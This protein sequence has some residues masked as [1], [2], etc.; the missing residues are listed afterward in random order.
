MTKFLFTTLPSNDLGLLTRSLPIAAELTDRGHQVVFCSPGDA[1]S[2]LIADAG[3]D[4]FLPKHPLYYLLAASP[5]ARGLLKVLE[6]GQQDFRGLPNFLSQ[7][8]Q[9]APTR[10]ALPTSQVWDM[11]HLAAGAG[12]RSKNYVRSTCEAMM[13]LI[14]DCGA[15]VVVDFCNPFACVGARALRKPLVTV[16][17]ANMHPESQGFI[18]WRKRPPDLPTP[19]PDLNQ[20]LAEYKLEPIAK[21]GE[22]LLGDLTLVV[23]MPETD[24]LPATAAVTYVGAILWQKP[25]AELP[26]WVAGLSADKP[27]IWAYTGNPRYVPGLR[28]P[29][30]SAAVLHA[31]I[32]ALADED[33]Q[34]V[35]TTGHHP[36][37]RG[38]LPLPGNFR[39]AP[40][41]PGLA[42]ARS[43]DLLIHHGGYGSCQTGLYTGTPAVIIPTY[44]ERES[45][46]RRIVAAGAG[47]L[48]V[49]A[50]GRWGKKHV[51][52]DELRAKV[53]KVIS[54]PSYTT[55]AERMG[56][57]LRAY[58]GAPEAARLIED[59]VQRL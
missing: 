35:L 46:A 48:V 58:G 43:S 32:E 34:I 51:L 31:C 59:L 56:R 16:I 26:D 6:A 14:A 5:N 2:R 3:F 50:E 21:T 7:L 18:W 47:D 19:V 54:E 41:V 1:P 12:M 28:T 25:G 53:R 33:M 17:Q 11:D 36:L 24:P 42:M 49:P 38:I 40:F 30:D 15:N 44:S 8:I 52:V 37:P 13:T 10:I 20:V 9:G 55:N 23:G 57:K 45:N 29:V 27:V 39:Y 4:N 22:L